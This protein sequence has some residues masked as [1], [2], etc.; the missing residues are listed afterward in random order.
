MSLAGSF[1]KGN[2]LFKRLSFTETVS[3]KNPVSK[4]DYTGRCRGPTGIRTRGHS[5]SYQ[6]RSVQLC[7]KPGVKVS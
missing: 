3:E 7:P 6:R 2:P 5:H 4:E 1:L